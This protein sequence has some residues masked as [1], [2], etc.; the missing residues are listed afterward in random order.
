[1]TCPCSGTAL[2]ELLDGPLT[3]PDR[4]IVQQ[5]EDLS[6]LLIWRVWAIMPQYEQSQNRKFGVIKTRLAIGCAMMVGIASGS[7]TTLGSDVTNVVMGGRWYDK[8]LSGAYRVIVRTDGWEHVSS[9]VTVEWISDRLSDQIGP[10]VVH[11]AILVG[12]GFFSLGA[13]KLTVQ[14]NSVR[15]ALSGSMTHSYNSEVHCVFELKPTG[16]VDRVRPCK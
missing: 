3:R 13:P 12:G 10:R 2:I 5:L 1:V 11:S 7:A 8:P 6:D 15:V 16:K 9:E 14:L 4:C